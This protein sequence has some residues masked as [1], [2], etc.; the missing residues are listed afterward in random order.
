MRK[1]LEMYNTFT[2]F[3]PVYNE[4]SRIERVVNYYKNFAPL[5]VIDNYSTDDTLVKVKKYNVKYFQHKNYG[6][7]QTPEFSKFLIDLSETDYFVGLSASEF[8]TP[9]LFKVFNDVATKRNYDMISCVVKSYTCGEFIPLWGGRFKLIDRRIERFYNKNQL[10]YNKVFMHA[11]F[12][13]YN[14]DRVL[15]LPTD[16]RY[17]I[18]HLRDSDVQSLITKNLGYARIEAQQIYEKGEKF[19]ISK[20]FLR[21]IKEIIRLFL[22]P[23]RQWNFITFREIWVRLVMHS[24][25]YFIARELKQNKGLKYS[26]LKNEFLWENLINKN[27]EY[28]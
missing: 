5:V 8:I 27:D 24:M 12:K 15:Y 3:L 9:S 4:S 28:K 6:S 17:N 13:V 26:I 1:R 21:I 2:M 18:I 14:Q 16:K 10:D 25:I 23:L 20:L 19:K 11:H 7:T 22:V